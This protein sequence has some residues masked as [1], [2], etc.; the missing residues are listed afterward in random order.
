MGSIFG[1]DDDNDAPPPPPKPVAP[2]PD[3]QS[4]QVLEAERKRRAAIGAR[5]GRVSTILTDEGRPK[6]G[7]SVPYTGTMLGN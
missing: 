7:A 6:E 5:Q 2:M 3:D 1:G 4:P